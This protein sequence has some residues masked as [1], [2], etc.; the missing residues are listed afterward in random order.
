[1][2]GIGWNEFHHTPSHPIHYVIG[3]REIERTEK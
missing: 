3:W 1:M 2:S